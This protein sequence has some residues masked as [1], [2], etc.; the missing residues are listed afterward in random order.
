MTTEAWLPSLPALY[1]FAIAGRL[2]SFTRAAAELHVTQ[3]AVSHQIRTLE[4]QLGQKLFVRTT[5]TLA[6]TEAGRRLWPAAH[7][8]FTTL[9]RGVADLRRSRALLTV[10]TTPFFSARWLAPRLGRF[11]VQYPDIEVTLR[12]TTAMLDLDAEGIDVAIRG[13]DGHWP[14]L[15]VHPISRAVLTPVASPAYKRRLALDQP[16]DVARAN[17]LHDESRSEWAEWLTIAGFD[18]MQANKGS[19][20]DDEHVLLA[21][22]R[23]GQGIA[24]AMRA[25]VQQD[26]D[27]GTL[28]PVF[29]LSIGP[30]WRY[31][32]VHHPAVTDL[33]KIAVFRDFILAEAAQDLGS[34]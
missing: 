25:L 9:E 34:P 26:F 18:P 16:G 32:L 17:L 28:T 11:A 15:V 14:G 22:A 13:G 27:D 20:F 6:L 3:A 19:V 4:E 23:N 1:V 12:H 31:Y 30:E 10:T 5:R 8:A 7:A 24:L 21:A 33:R 2:L 29:N